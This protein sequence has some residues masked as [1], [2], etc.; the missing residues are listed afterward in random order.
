MGVFLMY[1]LQE[2]DEFEDGPELA[3]TRGWVD[4]LTWAEGAT[5]FP[6][7]ARFGREAVVWP[8][9][10]IDALERELPLAVKAHGDALTPE[11]VRTV[12]RLIDALAERPGGALGA[13]VT[14]GTPGDDDDQD[15]D[16]DADEDNDDDQDEDA[17]SAGPQSAPQDDLGAGLETGMPTPAAG[18]ATPDQL[19]AAERRPRLTGEP[20][21]GWQNDTRE[22]EGGY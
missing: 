22:V 19:R 10:A 3:T 16:E 20:P 17:E 13:I 9:E 6:E 14:D 4:F 5:D 2:P 7:V 21:G 11:L 12:G 8:G 15:A 1:A 18:A